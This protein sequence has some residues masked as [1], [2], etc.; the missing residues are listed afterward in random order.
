MEE[1]IKGITYI[2]F[3]CME[4]LVDVIELPTIKEYAKWAFEGSGV[5]KYWNDF[6]HFLEEYKLA[7][8]SIIESLPEHKEFR[9]IE[10]FELICNNNCNIKGKVNVKVVAEKLNSNFWETYVSKCY[11]RQDVKEVLPSISKKYGLCVV[12]NFMVPGGIEE[13]LKIFGIKQYFNFIVTSVNEG[14]KKPH[15]VIYNAALKK[16]G[17]TPREVLFVGDDYGNDYIAPQKMGFNAIYLDKYGKFTELP[18]K[19]K[20]FYQLGEILGV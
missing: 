4:T 14:W 17:V 3:D 13:L 18:Y 5:E 11:V 7:R 1:I 8:K 15:P 20:D 16:A 9:T 10:R 6:E 2:F 19:V 12:S